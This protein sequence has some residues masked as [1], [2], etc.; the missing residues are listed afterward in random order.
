[1]IYNYLDQEIQDVKD[2]LVEN[3]YAIDGD[4]DELVEQLNDEL[5][6][7]DEVTGNASG[8][9][10]FNTRQAEENLVGNWGLLQAAVVE[11][12]PDTNILDKGAE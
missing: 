10:T 12:A 1:M 8:S 4:R 3:N 6:A 9:Y 7:S 11:L 2:Y 5:M